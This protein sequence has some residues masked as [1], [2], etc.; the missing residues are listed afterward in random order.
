MFWKTLLA[1]VATLLALTAAAIFGSA[2]GYLPPLRVMVG[3]YSLALG[4]AGRSI[5]EKSLWG[6][7]GFLILLIA[8]L[9]FG[10]VVR[11]G[12]QRSF[13]ISNRKFGRFLSTGQVMVSAR[14]IHALAAYSA[15][16]IKG[17]YEA[18]SRVRL[19]GKGWNVDLHIVVSPESS[20]PE[21][22]AEIKERMQTTMLNHTGL[23]IRRL[24][25]W[26]QLDPISNKK[27]VY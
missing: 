10:W 18:G 25:V 22:L 14:G 19:S 20:L 5:L 4:L 12:V 11:G 24:R 15:E 2:L 8:L 17:I 7:G 16:R 6:G 23:P 1:L 26:A 3:D 21:L 27:R 9:L 13:T